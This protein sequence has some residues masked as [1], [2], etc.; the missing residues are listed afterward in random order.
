MAYDIV[1]LVIGGAALIG[2]IRA[3]IDMSRN[4]F[5]V[6]GLGHPDGKN[7]KHS[8]EKQTSLDPGDIV[9]LGPAKIVGTD[10]FITAIP[11]TE[12]DF[13]KKDSIWEIHD[14]R[15][16]EQKSE[17]LESAKLAKVI[18]YYGHK[19]DEFDKR[20]RQIEE[21]QLDE[22]SSHGWEETVERPPTTVASRAVH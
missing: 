2:A 22:M 5:Y 6:V 12:S 13:S 19:I 11:R 8:E 10:Y 16:K 21:K 14:I 9:A 3:A 7:D 4:R 1:I 15:Q 20:I 17:H 18:E